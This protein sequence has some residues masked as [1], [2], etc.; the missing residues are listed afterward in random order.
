[1]TSLHLELLSLSLEDLS[2]G[3]A[4]LVGLLK[5]FQLL[6][7]CLPEL[8]RLQTL[9]DTESKPYAAYLSLRRVNVKYKCSPNL[10]MRTYE[11]AQTAEPALGGFW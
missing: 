10:Y 6:G 4:S 9:L 2:V 11:P 1:M 7:C 8:Q 3:D 5:V